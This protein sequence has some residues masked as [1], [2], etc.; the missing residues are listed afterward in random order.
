MTNHR[1]SLRVVEDDSLV[2]DDTQGKKPHDIRLS[3]IPGEILEV[4]AAAGAP[5][6]ADAAA[7]PAPAPAPAPPAPPAPPPSRRGRLGA[8]AVACALFYFR[9][10]E[11]PAP[12]AAKRALAWSPRVASKLEIRA[13]RPTKLA[14]KRDGGLHLE[15]AVTMRMFNPSPL[16]LAVRALNVTALMRQLG[17]DALHAAGYKTA[18]NFNVPPLGHKDVAAT[19]V[20]HDLRPSMLAAAAYDAAAELV[21]AR[22]P[23]ACGEAG[24]P[25]KPALDSR[26]EGTLKLWPFG[27]ASVACV[28]TA[29]LDAPGLPLA[30]VNTCRAKLL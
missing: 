10:F 5:P 29:P 6:A 19:L 18:L 20:L 2:V 9:E 3:I 13:A 17:S 26:L 30:V 1:V 24:P 28:M 4:P 16:P 11:G 23:A 22:V 12:H 7:A 8:L 14:W 27:G 15:A 25:R 21:C